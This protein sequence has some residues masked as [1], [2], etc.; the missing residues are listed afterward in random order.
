MS[1]LQVRTGLVGVVAL[2]AFAAVGCAGGKDFTP[3]QFAT[4][5]EGMTEAEVTEVLGKPK[6]TIESLGTTRMFWANK[7]KYYSISFKDGKV[8][9]PLAHATK[10]DYDM[11]L[12]LMKATK[13]MG[14]S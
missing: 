6:E 10:E 11:M 9:A 3:E 14:K 1:W 5:K 13:G 4:I 12:G 2:M 8:S 7:D